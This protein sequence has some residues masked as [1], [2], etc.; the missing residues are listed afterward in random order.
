MALRTAERLQYLHDIMVTAVEGGV[1]Y[2]SVAE[3]V[4]SS[5]DDHWYESYTLWCSEGGKEP[6]S[7]GNGT[8]D[9]C[10]GHQVT[11]DVVAKGLGLGTLTK[12]EGEAQ[13]I[14]WAYSQRE[15]VILANRESDAGEIDADDADCIVQ[16]GVFG[17]VIYG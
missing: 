3:T 12:A 6:V 4:R 13:D 16:L 9:P 2:W 8:D 1:G 5:N 15:H 14:G 11:P 10:K 7:C 17:K